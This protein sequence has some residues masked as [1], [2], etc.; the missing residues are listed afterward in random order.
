MGKA[1]LIVVLGITF[2]AGKTLT[3]LNK[4]SLPL[5]QSTAKHYENLIARN[6][7]GSGANIAISMLFRDPEWSDGLGSTN[8]NAG[9]FSATVASS[10]NVIELTATGSYGQAQKTVKVKLKSFNGWPYAIFGNND[11][12]FSSAGTGTITGDVHANNKVKINSGHIVTGTIT[13]APPTIAPPTVDWNFFANEATAAGQY[14]VGDK[15]FTSSGSPY[16]GVWYV[17][18]TAFIQQNVVII[19]TLVVR[20][21]CKFDGDNI[22]IAATPSNYPALVVEN[23]IIVD[24]NS[25]SVFGFVYAGNDFKANGN[26]L[27]VKGAI[28]AL[29]SVLGGG[30]NKDIAYDETYTSEAAGIDFNSSSHTSLRILSWQEF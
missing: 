23:S 28:V 8:F 27:T 11:V 7:A 12:D 17:T 24:K 9:Q 29:T 21:D 26:N 30:N 2:V 1:M 13:E 6:I 4:R 10:E 15:T 25:A 5:S 3:G 22:T 18:N 14:V 20:D 16:T 19:G